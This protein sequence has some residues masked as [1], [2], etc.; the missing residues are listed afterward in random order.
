MDCKQIEKL[1]SAYA[2][3]E[4]YGEDRR[5]IAQHLNECESCSDHLAAL[6]NLK[7]ALSRLPQ[8]PNQ[9]EQ[10]K[11]F[12]LRV[13]RR[14]TAWAALAGVACLMMAGYGA[15]KVYQQSKP[16]TVGSSSELAVRRSIDRDEI[17]Y[18][19]SDRLG[20]GPAPDTLLIN[21]R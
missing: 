12:M 5:T 19:A 14:R 8:L 10:P 17:S 18:G 20:G 2:D 7:R 21:G 16:Q 1:L 15:S 3:D 6:K 11:R 4:I 13:R 9:P